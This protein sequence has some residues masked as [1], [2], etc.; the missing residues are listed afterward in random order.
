MTVVQPL[1]CRSGAALPLF[2]HQV[3]SCDKGVGV[4]ARAAAA[5]QQMATAAAARAPVDFF[6]PLSAGAERQTSIDQR[7]REFRR[8]HSLTGRGCAAG[9]VG[10]RIRR[11]AFVGSLTYELSP[12]K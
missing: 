8:L 6:M 9:R 10:D 7:A 12:G 11:P 4:W 5:T 1:I 3:Q 2:R